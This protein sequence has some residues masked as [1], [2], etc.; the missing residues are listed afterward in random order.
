[1]ENVYQHLLPLC[2]SLASDQRKMERNKKKLTATFIRITVSISLLVWL[3]S[4]TDTTAV[5][6]SFGQ[7]SVTVW[8]MAIGLFL[9]LSTF[10]ASRWYC[11]ARIIGLPGRWRAYLT[12]YFIGLFFN[13]F[14]PTNVG[15]DV[16]KVLLVSKEQNGILRGASSVLGERLIGLFTMFCMGAGALALYPHHILSGKYDWLFYGNGLGIVALL[17]FVP[18][19][20]Y[21]LRVVRPVLYQKMAVLL[22][23]RRSPKVLLKLALISMAVN[24]VVITM[25]TLLAVNLGI[26]L[27]PSYYFAIYPLMALVTLLP[28]SFNG[29]GLREGAF[30][31]FLSLHNI[32]LE[33]AISLSLCIFIIQCCGSCVGGIVYATGLH[34]KPVS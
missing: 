22:E 12:Y 3:F 32:P 28:I 29:V 31:F 9:L 26:T 4:K 25:I 10:A 7:L 14:L 27:H 19:L 18:L 24:G 23:V 1:M 21:L 16:F 2:N 11:L 33:T 15:G 6:E 17:F 30:V 34:K 8:S 20:A 13:L 5:L